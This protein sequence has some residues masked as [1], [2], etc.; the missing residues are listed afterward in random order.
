MSGYRTQSIDTSRVA[1]KILLEAYG[2]MGPIEKARR[3]TELTRACQ[4]LALVG[5]RL[6]HPG[7]GEREAQLRLASLWLDRETM[8]R[9]FGWDS[10]KEGYG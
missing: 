3:V 10:R 1:E 7:T 9:V 2:E 5:I 8:I 6:R 4:D